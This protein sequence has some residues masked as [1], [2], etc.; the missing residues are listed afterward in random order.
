MGW[1]DTYATRCMDPAEA[2]KVIQSGAE[3]IPDGATLQLGIGA[4]PDA[5]LRFLKGK[6]DLGIHSEMISDGVVDLYRRGV[7]NNR[8]KPYT[9]GKW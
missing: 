7:I 3:L 4:I 6:N 5:A 9:P 2:V 8:V 1:K